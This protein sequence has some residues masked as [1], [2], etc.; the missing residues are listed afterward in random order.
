MADIVD[1]EKRSLMMAGIGGKD[2]KPEIKLRKGLWAL[3]FRYRKNVKTL[4]G[5]P[6]LV[7]RKYNAAIFVHGC[8]WHRHAGCRLT[9]TPATRTDFWREKFDQNVE[10]DNRVRARLHADG[11]RNGVVWECALKKASDAETTIAKVAT[12][13]NSEDQSF[14]IGL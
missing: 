9:T 7:L 8:F 14:E 6:D 5:T 13:L 2:T 1:K 3:G 12:W 4:P 11:W 10:R